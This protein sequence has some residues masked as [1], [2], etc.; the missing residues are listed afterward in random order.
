[1]RRADDSP[2]PLPRAGV[3]TRRRLRVLAWRYRFLAAAACLGLAAAAVEGVLRPPAPAGV[4]QLVAARNLPAGATLVAADLLIV[5]VPERVAVAGAAASDEARDA[6]VGATIA[7]P[8]PA[9][10]PLVPGVIAG[11][12]LVGPP[13]TVVAAVRLADDAMAMLLSPGDRVDLLAAPA[14]GGPG[15]TVATRALVLPAAPGP[16]AG[17]LF[18]GGSAQA[19]PLLVAVRP[20]EAA[21]LAGAGASDVLFAVVVS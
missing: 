19:A 9:G 16:D 12:G 7:V 11:A 21:A 3:P 2:P 15:V 13:G 18:G 1:M 5:T 17:G 4:D 8:V 10:L 14:E 6:L 20:D